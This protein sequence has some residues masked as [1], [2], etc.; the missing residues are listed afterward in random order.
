MAMASCRLPPTPTR[1]LAALLESTLLDVV[2]VEIK[3]NTVDVVV[4]VDETIRGDDVTTALD[5]PDFFFRSRLLSVCFPVAVTATTDD[6]LA[7]L[8]SLRSSLPHVIF[9]FFLPVCLAVGF[10]FLSEDRKLDMRNRLAV[11][12]DDGMSAISD[13]PLPA[14]FL[15][16]ALGLIRRKSAVRLGW[17]TIFTAR[18]FFFPV[19]AADSSLTTGPLGRRLL[20]DGVRRVAI[21]PIA[22]LFQTTIRPCVCVCVCVLYRRCKL[23]QQS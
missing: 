6:F 22:S 12:D 23:L 9:F 16:E 3:A 17:V 18:F 14:C 10:F 15:R 5:D 7:V 19:S 8:A 20:L 4:V 1:P 13:V 21:L 11:T 2:L